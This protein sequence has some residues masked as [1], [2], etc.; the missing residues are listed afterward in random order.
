MAMQSSWNISSA[1]VK[2]LKLVCSCTVFSRPLN[3]EL[4][5][6]QVNT[7]NGSG[8]TGSPGAAVHDED[9]KP[10][11]R[12]RAESNTSAKEAQMTCD[13]NNLGGG[14]TNAAINPAM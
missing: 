11:M 10:G 9:P 1:I 8:A 3:E 5:Y 12:R 6:L 2:Q 14:D 13:A 4:V 7:S